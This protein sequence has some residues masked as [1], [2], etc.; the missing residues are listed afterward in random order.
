MQQL[1]H[2]QL[3]QNEGRMSL[4]VSAINRNQF[5]SVRYTARTY[6]VDER[7]LR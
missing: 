2:A 6:D 7:T 3:A 1:P 5:K 4:A